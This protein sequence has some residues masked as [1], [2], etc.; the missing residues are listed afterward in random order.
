MLNLL[1]VED[2][3]IIRKL[4]V[5]KVYN[6]GVQLGSL[7]EAENGLQ[8]LKIITSNNI[9][10]VITD[11]RMPQIDG[12]ELIEHATRIN[13][14]I[15][16]IIISGYNDFEYAMR[17][18][19]C[20]VCDYITKPINP[21]QLQ[22]T[23]LRIQKEIERDKIDI[24]YKY[25]LE[26]KF[27]EDKE[28]IINYHINNMLNKG[29]GSSAQE[30]LTNLF[31]KEY[32]EI[33]II[34][35]CVYSFMEELY[36]ESDIQILN[37]LKY[38]YEWIII[39]NVD[40]PEHKSLLKK[41]LKLIQVIKNETNADC[42]IGVG[43]TVKGIKELIESYRKAEITVKESVVKGLNKVIEYNSIKQDYSEPLESNP[44]N[45]AIIKKYLENGNA[46]KLKEYIG[47]NIEFLLKQRAINYADIF[48]FAT[49]LLVMIKRDLQYRASIV[50]T[51]CEAEPEFLTKLTK[52]YTKNEIIEWCAFCID[53][54]KG[55][56]Q[57]NITGS[58]KE[59]IENIK[60][61]VTQNFN[62]A[63]TLD[64]IS[65][66]YNISANY[67]SRMFKTYN[68]ECFKTYLT[69]I[70]ME[71]AMELIA[72]SKLKLYDISEIVGYDD[73]KYFS[74]VFK[75]YFGFSPSRSSE[76]L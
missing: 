73:P 59:L 67:F 61:F 1:V 27:N 24:L 4:I 5:H 25:N 70:R 20:N 74:K 51:G 46:F 13:L 47:Y 60:A 53:W 48:N 12:L 57:N 40:D 33:S 29:Y 6:T 35:K 36:A 28:L 26:R 62:L 32:F 11:I 7:L 14:R 43:S 34:K 41:H 50:F 52:C 75:S 45:E 9:D 42:I 69:R 30:F 22:N 63:I 68:G 37:D 54:H 55:M 16:F 71:K 19:H 23:I 76:E 44:M 10:I 17:A 64:L 58:C 49:E 72:S 38:P 65:E 15:K 39:Y 8:A 18:L 66:K 31:S 56:L 3:E 21:N 2:Q